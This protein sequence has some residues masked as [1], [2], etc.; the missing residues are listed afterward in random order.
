MLPHWQIRDGEVDQVL[1]SGKTADVYRDGVLVA[2]YGYT[3]RLG[4]WLYILTHFWR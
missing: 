1:Y 2:Q 4:A 3:G